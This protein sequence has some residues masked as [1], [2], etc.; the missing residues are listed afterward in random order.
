MTRHGL[1]AS[2]VN[3]RVPSPVSVAVCCAGAPL[4]AKGRVLSV[5]HVVHGVEAATPQSFCLRAVWRAQMI[6]FPHGLLQDLAKERGA[7]EFAQEALGR[8]GFDKERARALEEARAAEQA[9]VRQGQEKVDVLSSG[10]SRM[11]FQYRDP[12][13]GFD[14]SKVK[15][16][17]L[18]PCS[19]CCP[20]WPLSGACT[21]RNEQS[22]TRA[23]ESTPIVLRSYSSFAVCSGLLRLRLAE[24]GGFPL[25]YSPYIAKARF[26]SQVHPFSL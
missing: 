26:M 15:V 13:R 14:R 23:D 12:E 3:C 9:A 8:L 11:D 19:R 5:F 6:P 10:L 25:L 16:R 22:D 18:R 7:V 4:T 21:T 1:F 24:A 2:L 17:T 20:A